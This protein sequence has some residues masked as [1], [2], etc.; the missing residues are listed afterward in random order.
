MLRYT[1]STK[2]NKIETFKLE[3][4][5]VGKLNRSYTYKEN[6]ICVMSNNPLTFY[7]KQEIYV[8]VF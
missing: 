1:Y 4:K 5:V 2:A 7:W 6:H 8:G 3:I